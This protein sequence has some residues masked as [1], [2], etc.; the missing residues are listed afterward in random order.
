MSPP[1]AIETLL[2]DPLYIGMRQARPATS[3][4]DEFVEEFVTAVQEEFPGCCIQ[5]EDWASAD[6]FRLLAQHRDRVCCFNDD[7]QGSAAL[8]CSREF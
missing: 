8:V 2:G 5:F 3:Q 6:A 4:L 7:I 1:A